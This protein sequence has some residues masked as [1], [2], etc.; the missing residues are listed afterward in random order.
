MTW[1]GAPDRH[2]GP[3]GWVSRS[4]ALSPMSP[5]PHV[6]AA[7]GRE[8]LD[9]RGAAAR[10]S[11]RR[12][13]RAGSTAKTRPESPESLVVT[14]RPSLDDQAAG[15]DDRRVLEAEHHVAAAR[16]GTRHRAERHE[17]R[18]RR[19]P[20]TSFTSEQLG[21]TRRT[22]HAA[23][24]SSYSLRTPPPFTGRRC[25]PRGAWCCAACAALHELDHVDAVAGSRRIAARR[26][27]V[28]VSANRSRR[29]PCRVS[30]AYGAGVGGCAQLGGDVVVAARRGEHQRGLPL[31]RAGE[32]LVGGGVAACRA[33]TTSGRGPTARPRSCPPRSR[34]P[35]PA[36][37]DLGVVL[38]GLLLHV[39]ADEVHREVADVRSGSG[40]R[41]TQVG[42]AAAEVDDPQRLLDVGRRTLPLSIASV[43][44]ASSSR[45]NS[46]T[47]RYFAC[48]SA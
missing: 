30:M 33:S 26:A 38:P 41:R 27:S 40:G 35:R 5:D 31:D 4:L 11:R 10:G 37:G 6:T 39:D 24:S 47:W 7:R 20:L 19:E 14:N 9:V 28:K 23:T 16:A 45:R 2:A 36:G 48:R 8:R 17:H 18:E 42:V 3:R 29:M 46:S 34:R 44:A 13:G 32:C 21:E 15:L 1:S 12:S 22:P 25:G 43:S